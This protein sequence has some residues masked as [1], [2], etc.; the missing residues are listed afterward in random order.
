REVK[1]TMDTP[2]SEGLIVHLDVSILFHLNPT[3]A[4]DVYRSVGIN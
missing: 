1:E 2:S 4:P 3:K